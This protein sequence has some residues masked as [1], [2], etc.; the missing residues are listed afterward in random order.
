MLTAA[1]VAD[2]AIFTARHYSEH[3]FVFKL[4]SP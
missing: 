1:L 4:R 3:L 2:L